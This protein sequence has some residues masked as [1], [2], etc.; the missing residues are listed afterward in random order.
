MLFQAGPYTLSVRPTLS[1]VV[2]LLRVF[3]Y[4]T[5]NKRRIEYRVLILLKRDRQPK[6][7]SLPNNAGSSI[8]RVVQI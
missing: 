2:T 1:H 5:R 4:I 7:N 6:P 3:K 8:Y